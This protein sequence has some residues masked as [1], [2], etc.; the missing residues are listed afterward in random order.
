MFIGTPLFKDGCIYGR[1]FVQGVYRDVCTVYR[2]TNA[3]DNGLLD[4][5]QVS[6]HSLSIAE[7]LRAADNGSRAK[8]RRKLASL[9]WASLN[10][11]KC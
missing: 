8:R 10:N 11:P 7:R 9:I 1:M 6:E 3:A 4:N 2:D 5:L